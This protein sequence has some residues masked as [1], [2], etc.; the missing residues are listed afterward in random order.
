MF[1][2]LE[3]IAS[4]PVKEY[5]AELKQKARAAF[6]IA[7]I[8][9]KQGKDL[10]EEVECRPTADL[11]DR[12]EVLVG[13]KGIAK[14]Y[15]DLMNELNG[16]RLKVMFRVFEE[17]IQ[18]KLVG[19]IEKEKRLDQAIRTCLVLMTEGVV[20][21]PIDG[22]PRI[23]ISKNFDGTEFVDIYYAG[24]IRAAGGSAAVFPL[25]LGD[26][27]RKLLGLDVYKPT[28]DEIERY[29]EEMELFEEIYARQYKT[30]NNEIRKIIQN[31]PV[32]INGEPVEQKEVS[33]F[34]DLPRIPHNRV[35]GGA[36]IVM[37]EGILLKPMRILLWA[38]M[39]G[40]DWRWLE[41]LMKIEKSSGKTTGLKPDYQ[42]LAR[43]A[44]GRPILSYPMARNGFR[45]RYGHARNIGLMG[46]GIHPATMYLLDEFIACGTQLKIER[47]GKAAEVFPV[48]SIEGP[49][50]LMNSGKVKRIDSIE[51]AKTIYPEVKKF[52]FLGDLLVTLGDFR[53][54]AHPLVPSGFVDEWW[55]ELLKKAL[56]EGKKTGIETSKLIKAPWN[57]NQEEAVQLSID[58]GI[59]LHPKFIQFYSNLNNEE[60]IEFIKA[61]KKAE[62]VFEKNSIAC[63][64]LEFNE[65]IKELMEMICLEHDLSVEGDKI[66]IG[67]AQAYPLLK[68]FG[69]LS[70]SDPLEKISVEKSVLEN[71]NAIS[72]VIIKDKAGTWI[73]VR[74]GRPEQ[75]RPRKMTGDPHVLFP[76]GRYGGTTRSM[77]KAMEREDIKTLKK[78]LIEVEIAL[79]YCDKCRALREQPKCRV[80]S[81]R[82][83]LIRQCPKCGRQEFENTQ[84]CK[85]CG[86]PLKSFDKRKINLHE[87][88]LQASKNIDVGI[89]ELVKGVEGMINE[90]KVAESIEK[91][92]LRAKHGVHIFKDG[93][94]RYESL[95][96]PLTHFK[97]KEIGLSIEKARELGYKTDMDGK[98]LENDLQLVELMPQD[99]I[100]NEDGADFFIKITK[101]LDDMLLRYYNQEPFYNVDKK[102][103]LIGHLFLG[104]AP[105]TS[106]AIIG[107]LIGFTKS[108]LLWA[109]PYF[110]MAKRRNIDG[111]QDSV[112]LLM[113]ALLNF[114]QAYLSSGRGGRMD[115][116]LVFT[117]VLNPKEID[118][119]VY[120]LET[121]TAYPLELYER[122]A[123]F[124]DPK[125]VEVEKVAELL[126]T[127]KQYTSIG[128]T[129]DTDVFDEGPKTTRYIQLKSMKEKIHRQAMLQNKIVAVE[130]KDALE[131]VLASHFMPDIIGNARAFSRQTFRCGKCNEIYRRVPLKGTCK[132]GNKL[133]L[134]V[135]EGS[136]IKY[137]EIAKEIVQTYH[138]SNY[139][140]QRL[141]LVEKEIKSIFKNEKQ[142]QASLTAFM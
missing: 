133:I 61:L 36:C 30:S 108:R 101:F 87:L 96:A 140:M 116:P 33:V 124:A 82:T 1:S 50:V 29:V 56:N 63:L 24:P 142:Q 128:L 134:T 91:G 52:L 15:R 38:K 117:T 115:A 42:F 104:L 110:H 9:K 106:A 102:E 99:I 119:E 107:R 94:I 53:K 13:P 137:L 41:E 132:C 141:N 83:R 43:I 105:H 18:G 31:C 135:A 81:S 126:G 34:R 27:G 44:A 57:I 12:C 74:M 136:V 4:V 69:L 79:F 78:G 48:N 40:L 10:S 76:I 75:A 59:P 86:S 118:S 72:Q 67:K 54:T 139:L 20:V 21:S 77:N 8:S 60:L 22:V 125:V 112:L 6:D 35:R 49:V 95:N 25:I 111:D 84:T 62:A 45:L 93:T 113:D 80:C 14:R 7:S 64:K 51:E 85:K 71:I 19:L 120:E 122:A 98:L 58:L 17:I 97:P 109:H 55:R 131:R 26:Y 100:I 23:K 47:P 65:K 89:P 37:Q 28:Q 103:A 88:M 138:L 70:D 46:K 68:T 121:C 127:E 92:L 129:H 123:E 11:A 3:I 5:Y 2:N 66:I 130:H 73:G 90:A 114:S 16:D 39:L 32:C